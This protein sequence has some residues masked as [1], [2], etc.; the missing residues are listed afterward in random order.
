[1]KLPCRRSPVRTGP[2]G[3]LLKGRGTVTEAGE[4][5]PRQTVFS[6]RTGPALTGESQTEGCTVLIQGPRHSE[7]PWQGHSPHSSYRHC[8]WPWEPSRCLQRSLR[9]LH[10]GKEMEGVRSPSTLARAPQVPPTGRPCPVQVPSHLG[11]GQLQVLNRLRVRAQ[12]NLLHKI[13]TA[14]LRHH[15]FVQGPRS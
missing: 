6:R 9:T 8:S 4:G 11:G 13:S 3:A 10:P 1:M 12:L 7:G 15:S 2:R 5:E 14:I